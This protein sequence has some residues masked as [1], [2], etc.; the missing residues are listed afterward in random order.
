MKIAIEL[1]QHSIV[2]N[3]WSALRI[4]E[5]TDSPHVFINPDL[6]NV[7]WNYDQPEET[8][9]T[10]ILTLATR[11]AYWHCKNLHRINV[12]EMDSSYFVRVPLPDGDLDYRFAISAMIDADYDGFL[13]IEGATAGDA[14]SADHRSFTY[15]KNLL[16]EINERK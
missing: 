7:Y 4:L 8:M 1:H 6:G 14:I 12:P 5:L 10:T 2:D 9:E 11:S 3:S 13:A 15:V 16:K